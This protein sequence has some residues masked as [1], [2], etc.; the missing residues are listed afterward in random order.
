MFYIRRMH[1][2]LFFYCLLFSVAWPGCYG[3]NSLFL[4]KLNWQNSLVDALH[5]GLLA[6]K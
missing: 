3:M 5:V 1:G 6:L 4:K 2:Y